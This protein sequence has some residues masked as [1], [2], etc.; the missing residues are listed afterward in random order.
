MKLLNYIG[1]ILMAI[2]LCMGSYYA[3][4]WYKGK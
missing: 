2:G 3:M 1:I 4:E